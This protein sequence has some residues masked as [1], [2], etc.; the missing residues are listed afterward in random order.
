MFQYKE[1]ADI[2]VGDVL[3]STS[4]EY[5]YRSV[6]TQVRHTVGSTRYVFHYLGM[7]GADYVAVDA[8]NAFIIDSRPY[9]VMTPD[10][11]GATLYEGQL[12][13]YRSL[14]GGFIKVRILSIN[15]ESKSATLEVTATGNRTYK[16]GYV[17]H[18]VTF[19]RVA[20]R[21]ALR[22]SRQR[23]GTQYELFRPRF[24]ARWI[25]YPTARG[26]MRSL[27]SK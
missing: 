9:D 2:K 27:E 16:R 25:D 21:D 19:N 1:L 8:P 18:D 23:P 11:Y 10:N 15:L 12:A 6:I 7:K 20:H 26:I 17:L 13:L 3:I 22:A 14:T 4:A 24:S 5:A